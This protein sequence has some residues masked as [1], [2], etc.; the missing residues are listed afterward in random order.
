V[1]VC[2]CVSDMSPDA[3]FCPRVPLLAKL[4]GANEPDLYGEV[5]G[6]NFGSCLC[7]LKVIH[8]GLLQDAKE[9]FGLFL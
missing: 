9:S 4:F 7:L 1:C 5:S 6:L 3:S 8:C 2:V